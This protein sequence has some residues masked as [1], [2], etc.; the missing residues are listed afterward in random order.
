MPLPL[1]SVQY[2]LLSSAS[3]CA[4]HRVC[5]SAPH[6][7]NVLHKA[8]ERRQASSNTPLRQHESGGTSGRAKHASN[9]QDD[10]QLQQS[11]QTVMKCLLVLSVHR[12]ACPTCLWVLLLVA[13]LPRAVRRLQNCHQKVCMSRKLAPAADGSSLALFQ[14]MCP[15]PNA[16]RR[17]TQL[18]LGRQAGTLCELC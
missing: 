14:C 18:R 6:S 1:F 2:L 9:Y 4:F 12:L 5:T 3:V 15:R 11:V 16:H 13:K 10:H 17:F 7:K 8:D